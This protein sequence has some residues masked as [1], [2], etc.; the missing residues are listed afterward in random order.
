MNGTSELRHYPWLNDFYWDNKTTIY[1]INDAF[2]LW[3]LGGII[4]I[5]TLI[6]IGFFGNSLVFWIY[7]KKFRA[8]SYRTYVLCLAAIDMLSTVICMPYLLIH[9]RYPAIFPSGEF[10]KIGAL[11]TVYVNFACGFTLIIIAIHRY[12]KVCRRQHKQITDK[13]AKVNCVIAQLVSLFFAFPAPIIY[14]DSTIQIGINNLNGTYCSTDDRVKGYNIH[15]PYYILLN[16]VVICSTIVLAVLYFFVIKEVRSKTI[17]T[18]S[19]SEEHHQKVVSK[20]TLTLFLVTCVYCVTY[21]PHCLLRAVEHSTVLQ[22]NKLSFSE[23]FAFNTFIW[24]FFI[25]NVTNPFVY[26]YAD[27]RF[28]K[29]TQKILLRICCKGKEAEMELKT[30]STYSKSSS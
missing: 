11:I 17:A 22:Y 3:N 13:Q 7:S 6:P 12:R 18:T 14:G 26:A 2:V 15:G 29:Q 8:S 1:D 25:N 20:T 19:E 21:L 5:S 30:S 27:R 23:G 9:I 16:I 28:R 4:L 24:T 10:C